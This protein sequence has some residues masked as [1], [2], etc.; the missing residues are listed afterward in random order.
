MLKSIF[1]LEEAPHMKL[2]TARHS[3]QTNFS[4]L[5]AAG[6]SKMQT[7]VLKWTNAVKTPHCMLFYF[8]PCK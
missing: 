7:N 3:K 1:F 2:I 8:W 6:G 5:N 4:S